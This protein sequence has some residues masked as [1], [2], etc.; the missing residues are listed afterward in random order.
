M[1][2]RESAII[3]GNQI[4]T[5]FDIG[6]LGA[7]SDR[8]LLDHFLRGGETSE[9]AF[10]T[11]V[12]RHGMMVLRVC[13]H[14]LADGHLA[15]DAFQVTFLLLARR[16]R[17]I[18]DPDALAGWLHRVA[19]RVAIRV[20]AQIRRRNDREGPERGM[21]AVDADNPVER[22]ELC[23]I[24]HEEIDRLGDTQRLPILL[25]ALGGLSHEEAAQRLR[26]PVG[27][28]KSRLVRGR[29]R[30]EGRLTRRGLAPGLAIAAVVAARTA[31]AA[32]V[33]LALSV[34][35]T[36]SA[37]QGASLT[38][39]SAWPV[40]PSISLL[41]QQE[42]SA[43]I[44][45]KL[46]Q[47][48]VVAIA[49]CAAVAVIGISLVGAPGWR[50]QAI[51][52]RAEQVP[53]GET[54]KP[55]AADSGFQGISRNDRGIPEGQSPSPVAE[56]GNRVAGKPES[57]RSAL[58]E[59]VEQAIR[60]G[61]R[62]LKSQQRPV[63]DWPELEGEGKTGL[64]SLA[65]LALLSAGETP[66]S[67]AVQ[68]ALEYLRGFGPDQLR[69]TYA[70]SLQTQ[71]FA[72]ADPDRDRLR[73]IA[74]V[75]WL[76]TAQFRPG[77]SVSLPGSWSYSDSKRIGSGDNS[78]TQYALLGLHAASEAGF[79]VKP[80]VWN[81]AQAYWEKSQRKDG[82]WAYT[83]E[84]PAS[85]ASMT[86]AGVSSL[87]VSGKHRFQGLEYLERD[88]I[89]DCGKGRFDRTILRG[90][91]WLTR[92]FQVSQNVGNGNQ[93]KFYYLYGLERA[94]RLSGVRFFGANNWFRLGAEQLIHDQD[95]LDGS[96]S[97]TL[98]E[99]NKILATS[100]A[101]LF[102][103]KGRAPV[104]ISKVRH[105]PSNDWNHDPDDIRNIVDRVSRDWQS[106]LNWQVVDSS[107]ATLPEL[108]QAPILFFNGHRA[109]EFTP[110]A[111]QN[112]RDYVEQGGTLMA[113]ACCGDAEFDQG[114][115]R[116]M[117][118]LFPAPD[119]QLHPLNRDHRVWQSYRSLDPESHPLWG[120]E[121]GGRTVIIYSPTD[122]SCYW[123]QS[124]HSPNNPAVI[125][126]VK[127]GQNIID[128]ATGREL[129]PDKLSVREA[130][131]IKDAATKR[132]ALRI[133]RLKHAGDWNIAPQ[134]IPNLMDALRKPPRRF[135]VVVTQKDLFPRDPNLIYHPLLYLRGRRQIAFP[136]EDREAL[137][138][139]LEPGGGTLFADA[140]F[141]SPAFDA[142][143]RRFVADLFPDKKLE[144]IQRND[145]LY[146]RKMAFDLSQVQLNKA[147]GGAR[148]FPQL[149]GVKINGHW[150]IIYSKDDIGCVLDRRGEIEDKGY[151]YESALMIFGNIVVYSAL[152]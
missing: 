98:I 89:R 124:E 109:P 139:Y 104:L 40:S 107:V 91:D 138:Q 81:L 114:F 63:G 102:L 60:R 39:R 36:R 21:I 117:K 34:A 49:A 137:R 26:W 118:E 84:S 97:G 96:W 10:A 25:C 70:I 4:R 31:A 56:K 112:L 52:A 82:S 85:S 111:R 83:A 150:A 116:L 131:E 46:A 133:A 29:R 15:E 6:A 42:L 99:R 105:L 151:T 100:F 1:T 110:A 71:V 68:N 92:N 19:R 55:I 113:D 47:A 143:F 136:K 145:E 77:E 24:V 147:A 33:P 44:L 41:F 53:T 18:R 27:T 119:S 74:N 79:P 87:I 78:N 28:V 50:A 88:V 103:A 125:N 65:T 12:E 8:G 5:L 66:D 64:T 38:A 90:I 3:L 30:L 121:Q 76:E 16:A 108:L 48:A 2:K 127:I 94:G 126:A 146:T 140:A 132:G 23:A 141:G 13:R 86:C 122:L 54:R 11:L 7:M 22:D 134:A 43:M 61:V 135:D 142:T 73:I 72:A 51:E 9:A 45:A 58:G 57:Q 69:S 106:L 149:E 152:P 123:N 101:V 14:L 115:R 17:S 59:E 93:W 144:P 148:G 37:L 80:E 130:R 75:D 67:P 128:H 20:L 32:Q 120:I 95:K 62:F 129:P 35:V